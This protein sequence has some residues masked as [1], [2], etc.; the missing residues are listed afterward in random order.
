[1]KNRGFVDGRIAK[2]QT[3]KYF[4]ISQGSSFY[5]DAKKINVYDNGCDNEYM[6]NEDMIAED[7]YI[8]LFAE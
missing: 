4:I 8:R 2:I 1:M 7:G 6:I 3:P 5:L